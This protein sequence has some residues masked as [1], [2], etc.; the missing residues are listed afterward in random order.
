MSKLVAFCTNLFNALL[1]KLDIMSLISFRQQQTN[2]SML[3][4]VFRVHI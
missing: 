4:D 2:Q 3:H 1:Y